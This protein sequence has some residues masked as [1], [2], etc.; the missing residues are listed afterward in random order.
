ML[1]AYL[2]EEK[3]P[4]PEQIHSSFRSAFSFWDGESTYLL[5]SPPFPSSNILSNLKQAYCNL[6]TRVFRCSF[7]LNQADSEKAI[8]I[9]ANYKITQILCKKNRRAHSTISSEIGLHTRVLIHQAVDIHFKDYNY[10]NV[11]VQFNFITLIN[12]MG[13]IIFSRSSWQICLTCQRRKTPRNVA[14]I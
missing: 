12:V 14:R 6:H 1:L 9:I 5:K 7:T 13:Q 3:K 11:W 4:I 8:P 10:Q 2:D